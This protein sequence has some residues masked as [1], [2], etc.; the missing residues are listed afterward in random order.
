MSFL[1]CIT[2]SYPAFSLA[3][4]SL[5]ALFISIPDIYF[6]S[7]ITY[8]PSQKYSI[9]FNKIF[10]LLFAPTSILHGSHRLRC[11]NWVFEIW[12]F[13][14]FFNVPHLRFLSIFYF[15]IVTYFVSH[16]CSYS[17]ILLFS[18]LLS[19]YSLFTNFH[20]RLG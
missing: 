1:F 15:F 7:L 6:L 18:F 10:Q 2:L 11:G 20:T 5:H 12:N 16:T 4:L 19:L 8:V 13:F 14:I 17:S 3:S 9:F